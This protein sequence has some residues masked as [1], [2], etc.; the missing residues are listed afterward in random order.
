MAIV[1]WEPLKDLM[2][3]QDRMNRL[4]E[5][6]FQR[7]TELS[8]IERGDWAPVVD[9]FETKGAIELRAEL[10]G[11]TPK[12]VSISL[13]N[14]VLTLSGERKMNSQVKSENFHR[15]ERSY[16]S[17]VRS[18]ALPQ[19]VQKDKIKAKFEQGV[20]HI[21]LPKAENA[22]PRQIEINIQGD[23]SPQ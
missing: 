20:L 1:K 16:G 12:D 3:F 15:I 8:P 9:I 4:F 2:T 5:D 14:D 7:K 11:M 6:A 17:F 18:F 21:I 10:P 13:E 23:E 19:R 22:E